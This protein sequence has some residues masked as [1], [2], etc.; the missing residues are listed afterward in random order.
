MFNF[1]NKFKTWLGF[2]EISQN[3]KVED[4][5]IVAEPE[6]KTVVEA[7]NEIVSEIKASAKTRVRKVASAKKDSVNTVKGAVRKGRPKKTD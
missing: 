7:D 2:S 5:K 3:S 6:A 1:L 4:N